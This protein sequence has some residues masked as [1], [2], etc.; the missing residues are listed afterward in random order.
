MRGSEIMCSKKIVYP[1][2]YLLQI[3]DTPSLKY[4]FDIKKS[5]NDFLFY[6]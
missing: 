6:K 4:S 2:A 1:L 5:T 3:Y